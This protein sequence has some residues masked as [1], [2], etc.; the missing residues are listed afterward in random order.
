MQHELQVHEFSLESNMQQ[1]TLLHMQVDLRVFSAEELFEF[2]WSK[3]T[4]M[5]WRIH[6]NLVCDSLLYLSQDQQLYLHSSICLTVGN[7]RSICYT[8]LACN[9]ASY[10]FCP[11]GSS[12]MKTLLVEV[13]LKDHETKPQLVIFGGL[14]FTKYMFVL[15]PPAV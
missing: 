10:L 4:R 13:M 1:I 11:H 7:T 9:H 2:F 3:G 14:P 8:T 12:T 6:G 15:T 5:T